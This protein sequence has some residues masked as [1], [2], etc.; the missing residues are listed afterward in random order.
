MKKTRHL[1][2]CLR[3]LVILKA[4]DDMTRVT[5]VDFKCHCGTFGAY[6]WISFK[7]NRL[8]SVVIF[9]PSSLDPRRDTSVVINDVFASVVAPMGENVGRGFDNRPRVLICFSRFFVHYDLR[10]SCVCTDQLPTNISCRL[11]QY[12]TLLHAAHGQL[13]RETV[14]HEG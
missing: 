14:V 10:V 5:I 4:V 6:N 2:T 11:S 13:Q 1:K 7:N 9:R 8:G 3:L 12:G